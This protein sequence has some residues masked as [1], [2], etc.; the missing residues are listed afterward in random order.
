M[1]KL[2]A[3]VTQAQ[4]AKTELE[5]QKIEAGKAAK[6]FDSQT[7]SMNHLNKRANN[8]N[9]HPVSSKQQH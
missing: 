4:D 8:P 9:S 3:L 1:L 7:K 6:R 5:E 2:E